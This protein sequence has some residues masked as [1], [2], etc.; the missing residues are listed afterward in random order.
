MVSSNSVR[1]ETWGIF[2]GCKRGGI[3][4]GCK[5][6]G[7]FNGGNIEESSMTTNVEESAMAENVEESSMPANVEESSV[8][9]NVEESSVAG[10]VEESSMA[11]TW[12]NLQCLECC[13]FL[14]V[15]ES[16]NIQG[17]HVTSVLQSGNYLSPC[18]SLVI[19]TSLLET[20]RELFYY[21]PHNFECRSDDEQNT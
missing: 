3:F 17:G 7:I 10:N 9:A 4:N 8:A 20:I 1:F 21:R 5:R 6:G 19:L 12:R 11:E 18:F 2:N 16:S 15:R 13:F 14:L